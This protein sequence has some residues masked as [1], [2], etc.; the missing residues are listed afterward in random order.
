MSICYQQLQTSQRKVQ[1]LQRFQNAN[2]SAKVNFINQSLPLQVWRDYRLTWD[3][4]EFGNISQV[5]LPPHH[6]WLPDLGVINGRLSS[7]FDF[8]STVQSR[9]NIDQSGR[10]TWLYGAILDVT[11][12][13]D[14]SYF[15]FDTQICYMILT[16][17]QSN[18]H[19]MV[20][21]PRQM[22]AAV[23]NDFLPNSNVSEWEIKDVR[24]HWKTYVS[25]LNISYQYISISITLQRQ[26][27]YFVVMVLVPFSMLSGLAC[28]IFTLNNIG[29]RLS[30][31]LSLILSMTMY[32][33]IVSSSAPRSMRNIPVLGKFL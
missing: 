15:P 20:M 25:Q 9:I 3:P 8:S 33:V 6:L 32:V 16:P 10:I 22:G 1:I 29:D 13:L 11:C 5:F 30:V 26:P 21:Q 7:D 23:E 27:L 12:P 19:H 17:W 28:L 2:I 14:V 18:V 4:R 31:A 24:F